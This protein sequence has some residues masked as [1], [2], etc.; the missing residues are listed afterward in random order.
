MKPFEFKPARG[1]NDASD[2][3]V[4]CFI[5]RLR[6]GIWVTKHGRSNW[7]RSSRRV[8]HIHSD[9]G[10]LLSW[11]RVT[12]KSSPKEPP[13]L[14]LTTCL[15]VRHA[16]SPDPL[17]PRF[18]GTPI[19]RLNCKVGD[20]F[21]SFALIFPKRTV[22]IT[23]DTVDQCKVL[24][25][26]FSALCFRLKMAKM[27]ATISVFIQLSEISDGSI[28]D[29]TITHISDESKTDESIIDDLNDIPISDERI[30]DLN[31]IQIS[32]ERCERIDDLN[33]IQ[34][35]DERIDDLNDI[36]E[37]VNPG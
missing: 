18:N 16:R 34:I 9:G 22:D 1:C 19:L 33:V 35:S 4:R 28:D 26:G 32:D 5:A 24:I 10:S 17:D 2:F 6:T 21:K 23:A 11:R 27:A 25:E 3:V 37:V 7:S 14:D 13:K 15:E 12:G 36:D 20:A 8:L 30:V 29:H 31:V